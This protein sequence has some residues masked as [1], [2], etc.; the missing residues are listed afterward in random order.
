MQAAAAVAC[1]A[2]NN[3]VQNC[4]FETGD[5]T[6]WSISGDTANMGVDS[7][8]AYTGSY[9]AYLAGLGSFNSGAQNF[10]VLGQLFPTTPGRSYVL[11]Y[12]VAHFTNATVTPDN[13]FAAA[14]DS[15]VI[16]SSLQTDVGYE[17][18]APAIPY[19]FVASSSTTQ[20][21]FLAED[22]N[23]DFSLD[24]VSVVSTPEPSSFLLV[25]PALG[26]LGWLRLSAGFDTLKVP[27]SL[28]FARASAE[29]PSGI[30]NS[31]NVILDRRAGA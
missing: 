19:P 16:F 23:F 17:S 3:L 7:F 11:N 14:I 24:D 29:P 25:L 18:Y 5:F 26:L 12:Y 4:G 20:V 27:K 6:G 28:A 13:V 2:T 30:R 31:M 8:D 15:A 1:P 10:S 9:G 21:S 22:A